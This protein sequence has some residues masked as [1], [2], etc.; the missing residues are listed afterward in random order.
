MATGQRFYPHLIRTIWATEF[1]S[2]GQASDFTTAATMLGDTIG[3]VMKTYCD[4]VH[5]DQHAKARA[6]LGTALHTG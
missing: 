3:V 2:S 5:K 6:F 4:V 1:L